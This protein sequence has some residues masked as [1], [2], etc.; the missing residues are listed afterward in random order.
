MP[1]NFDLKYQ[2]LNQNLDSMPK[3]QKEEVVALEDMEDHIQG[4]KNM[5]TL[6][7]IS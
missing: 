1:I 2:I 3:V 5:I 7:F 6:T 4:M